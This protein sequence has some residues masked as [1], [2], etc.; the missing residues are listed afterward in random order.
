[1]GEINFGW[2]TVWVPSPDWLCRILEL[3]D[4]WQSLRWNQVVR[5]FVHL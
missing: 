1:M 2:L 5:S 3:S 4:V